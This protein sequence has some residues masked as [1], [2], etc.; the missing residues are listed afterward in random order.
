MDYTTQAS[1]YHPAAEVHP[2][3]WW[4]PALAAVPH[5]WMGTTIILA[6]LDGHVLPGLPYETLSTISDIS[7]VLLLTVG[8]MIAVYA[9]RNERPLWTASWSSYTI[10]ALVAVPGRMILLQNPD[11]LVYQMGF[12]LMAGLA[13]AILYFLRFRRQPLHA[14]LMMLIFILLAPQLMLYDIIIPYNVEAAFILLLSV[15]AATVAALTIIIHQW[16]LGAALALGASLLAN[17]VHTL[18]GTFAVESTGP[19]SGGLIISSG[20]FLASSLLSVLILY[21][22]WMFWNVVDSARRKPA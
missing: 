12:L 6:L 16:A 15:M 8:L 2:R 18:L 4:E 19:A 20:V 17:L 5:L 13:I 9:A 10:I 3:T 11:T 1:T 21:G 7:L 14:L 22:P